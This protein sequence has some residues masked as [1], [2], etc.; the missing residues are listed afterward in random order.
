MKLLKTILFVT[1]LALIALTAGALAHARSSQRLGL[2]GV[3]TREIVGSQ[4]LE[5]VLP[6]AVAGFKSE[7]VQEPEVVTNSLPRDTSFGQRI[8]KAEDGFQ[9]QANVVL[10]GST[11]SSIHKP[12]ICMTAQG[13]NIDEVASQQ[14]AVH[15]DRPAP[16]ELPVKRLVATRQGELNGQVVS[17]R[18]V[19]VYWFV[20]G[21]RLTAS[22]QQR[23]LWTA[24][25]VVFKNEL[26]RWA[27]VSFFAVCA[28]GQEQA[29]FE[30]MK[31]LI[32]AAVPEFQLAPAG[33]K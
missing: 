29:A 10:M 13:W 22:H 14:V 28:P 26:D 33:A 7:S 20:D 15:V 23:L 5:V 30:R 27:Y 12:E 3:K 11:R 32:V 4:N 25:D 9:V 21:D 19:Y 16:Y 6:A 17:Q 1:V 2:P 8:Y 24:R 31:N 18:G